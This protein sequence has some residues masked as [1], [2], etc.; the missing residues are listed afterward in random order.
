MVEEVPCSELFCIF[1]CPPCPRSVASKLGFRPPNPTYSI[2]PDTEA[3]KESSS[4]GTGAVQG[5]AGIDARWKLHLNENAFFQYGQR[6]L[7]A[8]DVFM[9]ENSRGNRIGCMFIHC[10]PEARFTILFSHGNGEDLG[11][12]SS[13]YI[14]LSKNINCNIFSYDYSGYGVSTGKPSEKNV[15]ADIDA[16]WHALRTRYGISPENIILYGQSIGSVPTVDLASRYDCAAVV[17]HSP[18]SSGL[19]VP[20]PDIKKTYC[21]DSFANIDK[22][23]K[24][25]SPVLIIHGT[26]DEVIHISQG[27]ALYDRCTNSL[28]PLWVKGGGHNDIAFYSRYIRRLRRL[29]SVDLKR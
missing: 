25:T 16:A 26:S 15:Y 5:A 18:L 12:V 24:I 9:T 29:I 6:E 22:V 2:E 10:I 13:F 14:Y 4:V 17:L 23:S 19:R 21:C 8:I 20:F 7:D 11:L 3:A 1:C 28:E 27:V